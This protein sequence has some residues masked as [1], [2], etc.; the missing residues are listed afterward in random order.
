MAQNLTT[1]EPLKLPDLARPDRMPSLPAWVGSRIESVREVMQKDASGKHR[2]TVVLPAGMVLGSSERRQITE[3]AVGLRKTLAYTP[4]TSAEAEA[5]MLVIITKMMLAKPGM[6]SSEAGAE[7]TGEVYQIAL[8]DIP[9]WA[10]TAALRR[11]YRRDAPPVDKTPHDYRWRPS[12]GTLRAIAFEEASKVRGRAIE[13]E[14]LAAAVPMIEFAPDT[15]NEMI[16]KLAVIMPAMKFERPDD[17][18]A[19]ARMRRAE[20][21]GAKADRMAAQAAE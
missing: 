12:E 9:P 5:E 15:R 6:R 3:H 1:I 7:A 10:V 14:R 19:E 18:T 13:L 16:D 2:L 17:V 11:W 20:R 8:E 21:L 4:D